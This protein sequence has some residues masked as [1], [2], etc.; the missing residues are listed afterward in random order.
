MASMMLATSCSVSMPT[1][2][3][4]TPMHRTFLSWNLMVDLTS[5][6][7]PL[8]SSAC[9]TGV[10]NLPAE[11]AVSDPKWSR[12]RLRGGVVRLTLGQTRT[13]D[14][15]NLPHDG[16]GGDEGIV[17]AGQLLDELLVLVE[18]LQVVG[19]HGVNTAVLGTVQ[20]VLV[21]QNAANT[22]VSLMPRHSPRT[23]LQSYQI[24]ML[25][26]GTEGSLM[27][28]EKRLSRWGS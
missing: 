10:G 26:R 5:V 9:E 8:R 14:T 20:V 6:I 18:L 21:T 7:L 11:M 24:D 2:P 4:A 12:E 16:V 1:L 25:G 27:V 17:L 22:R 15:G 19:R 28:P 23:G 13:D 3:T